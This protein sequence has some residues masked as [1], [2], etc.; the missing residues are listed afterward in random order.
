VFE[1]AKEAV[2]SGGRTRDA[3]ATIQSL[4]RQAGLSSSDIRDLVARIREYISGI[5]AIPSRK[6][7]IV[8]TIYRA[9]TEAREAPGRAAGG[10]IAGQAGFIVTAPT[11]LVGEGSYPTFAGPG[12]EAVIPL[13]ARG[14]GILA[15]A[16]ER[17]G[18]G[19]GPM[20]FNEYNLIV[21]GSGDPEAVA[22]RVMARLRRAH[23]LQ[24]GV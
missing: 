8:E 23:R 1:Y 21:E 18:A 19:G 11:Y 5:N 9:R 10:I 24:Q 7:T 22:Q 6:T 12:A 16:L 2:E 14:L 15:E 3:V 20:Q 4:G 13:G 17:A